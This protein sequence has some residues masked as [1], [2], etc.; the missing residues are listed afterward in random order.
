MPPPFRHRT[1][2]KEP[3]CSPRPAAALE[4]RTEEI[5]DRV[6]KAGDNHVERVA[7]QEEYLTL[8]RAHEGETW[9]D[10]GAWSEG[11]ADSYLALGRVDNAVRTISDATRR[12]YAEGAEL[13]CELAKKLVHSGH[14]PQ[15]RALWQQARAGY[16]DDVWVYVHA[17]IGYGDIGDHAGALEWLTTG[18]ELALRTGD[19]ESALEQLRPLRAS[20]LSALGRPSG[21]IQERSAQDEQGKTGER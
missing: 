14:E 16:P 11:L 4:E 9:F 7:A 8:T 19:P 10:A 2:K 13:L 12:G 20:C 21:E 5:M 1:T 15:A 17:G 3:R 18:L 6:Q